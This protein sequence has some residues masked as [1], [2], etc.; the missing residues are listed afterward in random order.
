V[1]EV[2]VHVHVHVS[3]PIPIPIPANCVIERA[4]FETSCNELYNI[5]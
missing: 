5:V 1:S 4:P 2:N 3:I